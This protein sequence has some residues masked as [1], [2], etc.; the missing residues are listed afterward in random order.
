MRIA[1]KL[2]LPALLFVVGATGWIYVEYQH[3]LEQPLVINDQRILT[4]PSGSNLRKVIAELESAG[5][6]TSGWLLLAHARLYGQSHRIQAGE[7]RLAVGVT[8]RSLLDQL[9]SGD[10]IQ[11]AFTIVEGWTFRQLR[12]AL[13]AESTLVH[14]LTGVSAEQLMAL[15]G[16]PDLHPE[17]QFLAE[18]YHYPKGLTDVDFLRRSH[19]ALQWALSDAWD[20]RAPDL[21]LSSPYQ[22]LILASIIEK[23]TALAEERPQIAG[24]F[25]RRLTKR[26]RLEAD[27]SV[28]YGLGDRFDGDLRSRDLRT[29]TPYNTYTRRG[30]P[31]TPI[32]II[33]RSAI[34]AALHP[35][36]GD[37][38]YF[39]AKGDGSHQFSATYREHRQ[40]VRKYQLKR[41]KSKVSGG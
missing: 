26:M 11:Y 19:L 17:G 2:L 9:V 35:L 32:A 4:V 40:A 22:A 24:V 21:P 34:E 8:P 10:V 37:M 7:Y 16:S 1:L 6:I 33:G 28:I 29:D 41:R 5:V 15:I 13:D 31:P 25:T 36:A 38:L 30:L 3:W 23:E 18:T 27:P 39:V 20:Q 12:K 14:S